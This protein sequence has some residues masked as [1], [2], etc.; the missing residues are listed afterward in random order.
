VLVAR[1]I[2]GGRVSVIGLRLPEDDVTTV[3][4]TRV[5]AFRRKFADMWSSVAGT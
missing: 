1:N 2:S 4:P 3:P 5:E